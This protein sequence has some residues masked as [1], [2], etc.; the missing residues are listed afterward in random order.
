M[1]DSI[2]TEETENKNGEKVKRGPSII[3]KRS[4]ED[5]QKRS[6][7]KGGKRKIGKKRDSIQKAWQERYKEKKW[8]K[9]R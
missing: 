9:K 8:N 6:C 1:E 4:T 5:K 2:K 7:N 3:W